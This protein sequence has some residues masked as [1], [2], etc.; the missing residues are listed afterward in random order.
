MRRLVPLGLV[1]SIFL[2]VLVVAPAATVNAQGAG[3]I[4]SVLNKMEQNK[5]SLKSLKSS[6]SM[7]K[8]NSQ[9][10]DSEKYSGFV[11]YVPQA[12]RN[13]NV[14]LEWSSPQHEILAVNNGDYVLYRPRL[15]QAYKGKAA[16]AKGSSKANSLLQFLNMSG[17]Q[18]K[19]RF[20]IQN[21]YNETIWGGVETCHLTLM[22][23]GGA[24]F[25]YAEVWVDVG[26]GMPVQTKVIEKNDDSTT[27][28]LLNIER[29]AGISTDQFKID[30]G[31]NVRIIQG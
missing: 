22:P 14:R 18:L 25:K 4:S 8:Y 11:L 1:A 13:A 26:S 12:G 27:I 2:S 24:S 19:A 9:L 28:R 17:S 20:E 7:E 6:I 21:A 16:Q 23:K 3:L 15:E 29:N 30:L 5:R 10:R 31:K